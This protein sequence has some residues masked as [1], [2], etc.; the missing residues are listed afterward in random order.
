MKD[1][2]DYF[3]PNFVYILGTITTHH[4]VSFIDFHFHFLA[5]FQ[6]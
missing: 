3:S 4:M 6:T 5:N 2:A 1:E